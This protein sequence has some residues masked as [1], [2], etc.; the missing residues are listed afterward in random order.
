MKNPESFFE[1]KKYEAGRCFLCREKTDDTEAFAHR[2][3][4]EAVELMRQ[5][6]IKFLV[7][8]YGEGT[9][10]LNKLLAWDDDEKKSENAIRSAEKS[11]ND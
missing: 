4:C 10:F 11:P 6:R 7:E 3:C 9:K 1:V 5:K 8:K 2:E